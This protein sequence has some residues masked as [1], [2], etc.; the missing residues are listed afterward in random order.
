MLTGAAANHK[1]TQKKEKKEKTNPV[2][3]VTL[4]HVDN[5]QY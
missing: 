1:Y 4:T 2:Q 5:F 3:K